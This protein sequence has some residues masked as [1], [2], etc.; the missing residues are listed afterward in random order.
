M[1]TLLGQGRLKNLGRAFVS[2]CSC[3]KIS[4]FCP[5]ISQTHL[6]FRSN[7]LQVEARGTCESSISR[8]TREGSSGVQC[9]VPWAISHFKRAPPY[10]SSR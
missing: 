4:F 6:S 5:I 10:I 8:A 1:L 7:V 9:P 2:P 3:T